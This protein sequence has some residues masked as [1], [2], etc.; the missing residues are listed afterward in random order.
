MTIQGPTIELF[1]IK[2]R[3]FTAGIQVI[4]SVVVQAAPIVNYMKGWP[5]AKVKVYCSRKNFTI[6][7]VDTGANHLP[8]L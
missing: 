8:R 3:Y 7:R 1:Q 5:L 2:S 4:A 6:N